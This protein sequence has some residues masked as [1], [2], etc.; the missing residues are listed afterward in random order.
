MTEFNNLMRK[1]EQIHMI[2]KTEITL[3]TFRNKKTK[4]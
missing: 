2:F 1:M 4:I 3:C